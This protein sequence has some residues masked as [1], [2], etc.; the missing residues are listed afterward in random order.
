LT[1]ISHMLGVPSPCLTSRRLRQ[2]MQG[3]STFLAHLRIKKPPAR[4]KPS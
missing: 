2:I 4:Q 3:E 1:F